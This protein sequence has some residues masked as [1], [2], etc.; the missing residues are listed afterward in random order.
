MK[1]LL[2]LTVLLSHGFSL[3]VYAF[4][5]LKNPITRFLEKIVKPREYSSVGMSLASANES[6]PL[7]KS[8]FQRQVDLFDRTMTDELNVMYKGVIKKLREQD[9]SVSE[10]DLS[11]RVHVQ[12]YEILTAKF[13]AFLQQ[14]QEF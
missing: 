2:F 6:E 11:A 9:S 1:K 8:Y 12:Y 3:N 5:F 13:K 4:D 14:K 7:D 10:Q